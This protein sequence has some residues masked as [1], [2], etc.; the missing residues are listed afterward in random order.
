MTPRQV[1]RFPKAIV[2]KGEWKVV[3]RKAAMPAS[4]FPMTK[5]D[6]FRLG[7]GW[8]WR[9]DILQCSPI[10]LRLLTAFNPD[11]ENY[12][13]WLSM[14]RGDN[15]AVLARLEYHSDHG[16][17]C[18][19]H[20][21]APCCDLSHVEIGQPIGRNYARVPGG[22]ER[23]RRNEFGTTTNDWALSK[24]FKFFRVTDRAEGGML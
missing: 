15:H 7:R 3:T 17:Q 13:A 5:R 6:S 22:N 19:W 16:E 18:G 2:T 8:H 21:H 24:A 12:L 14:P 4:A 11:T 9:V 10:K 1:I 23:H 20:C